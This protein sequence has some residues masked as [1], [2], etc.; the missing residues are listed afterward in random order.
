MLTGATGVGGVLFCWVFFSLVMTSYWK[1]IG[2]PGTG[3]G[4][5]AASWA[6]RTEVS[7]SV[8]KKNLLF[9]FMYM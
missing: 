6:S 5:G 9:F 4:V 1:G 7:F 2:Q 8:K 3:A